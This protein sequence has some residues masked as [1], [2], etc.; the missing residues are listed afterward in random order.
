MTKRSRYLLIIIGIII[1]IILAPIIALYSAGISIDW[2]NKNFIKTGILAFKIEPKNFNLFLDGQQLKNSSGIIRFLKPKDYIIKLEKE[3][4]C[5]WQKQLP[6]KAGEVTWASPGNRKIFLLKYL[7]KNQILNANLVI[8]FEYQ[9][10]IIYA[11]TPDRLLSL[12]EKTSA[13]EA[14]NLPFKPAG[15]FSLGQNGKFLIFAENQFAIVETQNKNITDISKLFTTTPKIMQKDFGVL[16]ALEG[17]RLFEINEKD[18][19]KKLLLNNVLDFTLL[20][21]DAYVISQSETGS[22][23]FSVPAG[24]LTQQNLLASLPKFQSSKI[25][26]TAQKQI[27]VQGNNELYQVGLNLKTL[28]TIKQLVFETETPTLFYFGQGEAQYFDFGSGQTNLISRSGENLTNLNLSHNLGYAFWIK[29]NTI[30]ALEIDSRGAQNSCRIY[31]GRSP[32]KFIFDKNE[33]KLFV[34]DNEQ[35]I[36]LEIR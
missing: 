18:Y 26:I 20:E 29:N 10:N 31:E 5:S 13:P 25:F 3:G 19:S 33:E 27:F 34:L 36:L 4:Y 32:K 8:D 11:L 35:I 17:G 12:R 6:V 28:G 9:N 14:V 16:W 30:E 1:F 24:N 15:F 22:N 2:K 7:P 23:L 21:N